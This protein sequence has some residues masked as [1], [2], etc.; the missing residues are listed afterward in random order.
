MKFMSTR[1]FLL[2]AIAA[3]AL[4]SPAPLQAWQMDPLGLKRIPI[5]SSLRPVATKTSADLDHDGTPETLAITEGHAMLLTK[6]QV[7]WQSPPTW[8]VE[9]AQ[10]TDLNYDGV[11]EVTLLV[12]RPFKP[13]PVDTWLPHGGRI[14][15]F[16]D[17]RGMSCHMIL[18]GWKQGA[19]REVWA[20]SAMA[21]PVNRFVAADLTGN[22]KQYLVTLEGNYDDPSSAPARRLKVWE[23]NGFGFTVVNNLEESF[24]LMG[25]AQANNKQVLILT[26]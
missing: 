18:I 25:T 6:S 21:D 16:H 22:G 11:P 23:W 1:P 13:W 14:N 12:W 24:S 2:L 9:Q 15:S 8:R 4:V 17:S 19:F 7:R 3:V 5:P 10:I 26:H 20:G